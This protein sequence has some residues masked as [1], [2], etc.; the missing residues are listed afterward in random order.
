MRS[1]KKESSIP[2]RTNWE[3]AKPTQV[4]VVGRSCPQRFAKWQYE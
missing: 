4:G 3:Q 2:S 1:L